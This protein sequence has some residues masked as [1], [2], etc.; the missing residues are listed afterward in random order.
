MLGQGGDEIFAESITGLVAGDDADL[1]ECRA[2]GVAAEFGDLAALEQ[3]LTFAESA[4][5][6]AV[7]EGFVD[8][9]DGIAVLRECF[10]ALCATGNE[11]GVVFDRGSGDE[12]FVR[13]QF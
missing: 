11:D 9:V 3:F 5:G 13:L 7:A 2:V 8:E 6:F 1:G 4:D 10:D 12:H